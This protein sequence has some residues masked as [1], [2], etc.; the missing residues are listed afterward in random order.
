MSARWAPWLV[1]LMRRAT[2]AIVEEDAEEASKRM[3]ASLPESD[4]RV[5]YAPGNVEIM[6]ESVREGQ[7]PGWRGVA[8]DDVLVNGEWGFDVRDIPVRV[9]IWHG[10]EDVN[11]PAHAGEYLRDRIPHS[12]ATFL[13]GEG[14][15][16]LFNYWQQVLSA[17]VQGT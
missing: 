2:H 1:R 3:M 10:T 8:R 11:V 15:F 5:L 17:L 4:K 9:D 6:T 7:R 16:F 12:R 13:P 14:H